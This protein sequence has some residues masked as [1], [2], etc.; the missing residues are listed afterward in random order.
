MKYD[1]ILIRYGELTLKT[2]NRMMFVSKLKS[3]M[4]RA[5]NSTSAVVHANRDR[6]YIDLNNEDEAL[7][8][9]KI[10]HISGIL[11]MS[12]VVKIEKSVEAMKEFAVKFAKG[13]DK[14][15][16]FKIEVKRA[17]K[18][19]IF[20]THDI[21]Q[22]LGTEVLMNEDHLIVDVRKPDYKLMVEVRF[23]A[24]YMYSE[25]LMGVGGLPLGTGGKALLMLSGGIDSPVAGFEI[26]KR[27]VEIE[28][29]HFHSPPYTSEMALDKVKKLID[30]MSEKSGEHIK[31]HVIPFTDLQ[32]TIHDF[33]PDNLSMTTTRRIMLTL[34]EKLATEIGAEAIVNG[35][36]LGQVASQTL[37]S[38][39]AI[40]EV[41]SMPV[42]RPLLTL[43]KNEIIKKAVEF[44]T[45]E[46][47][48]LP[49][50]D[51]CTIFKPKAPKTRPNLEKVKQFESKMDITEKLELA[52]KNHTIYTDDEKNTSEFIDLL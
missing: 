43:E 4:E 22:L 14:G 31:L 49:Y 6:A 18:N 42:L 12:P 23:D 40:N 17:D 16:T 5:L 13:F 47:S 21:Q 39:F 25:V 45:Y 11:S 35:E 36:N 2:K 51:C 9:N 19:F 44:E 15:S 48:I 26:M 33:I 10:K 8:M 32:T 50:E 30:I 52:L 37:T 34:A 1:H 27:G 41:T 3:R 28:A 20:K 24:I 46:T 29:I 38:M 7:V